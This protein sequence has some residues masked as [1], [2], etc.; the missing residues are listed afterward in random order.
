MK[1]RNL[2]AL[3][4]LFLGSASRCHTQGMDPSMNGSMGMGAMEYS[5]S[6]SVRDNA[7]GQAVN[8]VRVDLKREG[9]SVGS[10]ITTNNG[11]FQFNSTPSGEYVLE[12][13]AD[14]Y[15]TADQDVDITDAPADGISIDL[16]KRLGGSPAGSNS[17][18]MSAHESS[19][20]P[21]AR[22]AY[23][24]GI[25][26]MRSN[27]D[28]KAAIIQFQRAIGV[29]PDYYEAYAVEGI[30][31][32]SLG[33]EPSAEQAVRKSIELSSGKYPEAL[34]LL[35][36]IL[37]KSA[38]FAE[39]E[40]VARQAIALDATAWQGYFELGHAL[41]ALNR[42]QEA[43]PNAIRA[44]DL[45]PAN[46]RAFLLLANIHIQLNNS[47]AELQDLDG[48]LKIAPPGPQTDAVRKNRD[49]LQKSVPDAETRPTLEPVKPQP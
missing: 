13:H 37:N 12:V 43:E 44:R 41:S 35:A 29:F 40:T 28:Y 30:S 9:I 33:D 45:N 47:T 21:K 36:A 22:D 42:P 39:A 23:N 17:T 7:T 48:Y 10:T 11:G 46:P 14:G 6:G 2:L 24:K 15:E 32:M 26:L 38:R 8:G 20:P 16:R 4:V 5:I 34:F 49:Q 19:V 27:P 25:S 3:L 18:G 31:Y 1:F